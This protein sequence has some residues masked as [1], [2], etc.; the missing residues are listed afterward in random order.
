MMDKVDT[1]K[2]NKEVN[3]KLLSGIMKRTKIK[4]GELK[5]LLL[6]LK[7]RIDTKKATRFLVRIRQH[8]GDVLRD[9]LF[10]YKSYRKHIP[11]NCNGRI[12]QFFR[13]LLNSSNSL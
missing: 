4:E 8:S 9:A 6:V 7:L 13:F 12:K 11:P 3:E 10:Q 1:R 2:E 5:E